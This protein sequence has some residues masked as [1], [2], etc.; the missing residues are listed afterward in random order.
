MCFCE[1]HFTTYHRFVAKKS[2]RS[3]NGFTESPKCFGNMFWEHKGEHVFPIFPAPFA[4][5]PQD[6]PSP[7][8]LCWE[9]SL[10]KKNSRLKEEMLQESQRH[11]KKGDGRRW[12]RR[13]WPVCGSASDWGTTQP[14]LDGHVNWEHILSRWKWWQLATSKPWRACSRTACRMEARQPASAAQ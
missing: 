4:L 11:R 7:Y 5:F 9:R 2:T 6:C 10:F 8:I 3:S 14:P 13:W 1:T 12:Q